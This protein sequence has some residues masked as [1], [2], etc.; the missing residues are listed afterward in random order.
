MNFIKLYFLEIITKHYVDFKGCVPRKTFWL[1]SLCAV[2]VLLILYFVNLIFIAL[3][4]FTLSSAVGILN[5]I[6]L[7]GLLLPSLSIKVRRLH[8]INFRGW[9]LLIGIIPIAVLIVSYIAFT[10][11]SFQAFYSVDGF[12]A[13]NLAIVQTLSN[14]I[15]VSFTLSIIGAVVIIIFFCLKTKS[16]RW[17][18][19]ENVSL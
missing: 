5:L 11:F 14:I 13:D 17:E 6:V 1:F 3:G 16:N 18:S 8:D 15:N 2:I 19:L 7:L 9:W 10:V 4:A 12:S